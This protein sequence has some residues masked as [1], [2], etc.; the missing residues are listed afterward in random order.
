MG[1][2]LNIDV[3]DGDTEEVANTSSGDGG[4]DVFP[5]SSTI[6][7]YRTPEKKVRLSGTDEDDGY[8]IVLAVDNG[9][10]ASPNASG[11]VPMPCS[12]PMSAPSGIILEGEASPYKPQEGPI[13]LAVIG[14]CS[15]QSAHKRYDESRYDESRRYLGVSRAPDRNHY[16]V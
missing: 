16:R 10:I 7:K 14:C 2:G 3:E 13:G 11:Y 5:P 6:A 8:A 4:S 12:S 1:D 9:D 15:S